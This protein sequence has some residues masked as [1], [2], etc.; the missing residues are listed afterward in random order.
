MSRSIAEPLIFVQEMPW[1]NLGRHIDNAPV[2]SK[3]IIEKADLNWKVDAAQMYSEIHGEVKGYHVIYRTDNNDILGV[4]NNP[5]PQLVQNAETFEA[6]EPLIGKEIELETVSGLGIGNQVFG[7]FKIKQ[8]YNIFDD[9]IEHYYVVLN[10]HLKVD[11][12]VTILNTP[13]R[14]VCQNSL[15]TALSNNYYKLRVPITADKVANQTMAEKI[16]AHSQDAI[17]Y[18]ERIAKKLYNQKISRDGI[19]KLLDE[20]FPLVKTE[21]PGAFSKQNEKTEMLRET[22]IK[23]CLGADNLANVRGT[24]WQ[25][26]NAV[27]DFDTHYYSKVDK[28]YDLD[29]RMSKLPGVGTQTETSIVAKFFKIADKLA[30]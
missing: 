23:D 14:V 15:A 11:G 24:N 20:L 5:R 1:T 12:K 22:F 29:Y 9:K 13:I 27:T 26:Y 18:L 25:I 4:V 16:L 3:E 7:C 21:Y 17:T 6:V 8:E 2:T 28:A 30:A 19:D 10:D